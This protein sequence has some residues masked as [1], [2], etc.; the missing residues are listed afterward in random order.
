MTNFVHNILVLCRFYFMLSIILC[1]TSIIWLIWTCNNAF[2]PL[3]I[4]RPFSFNSKI[5]LWKQLNY[6][7]PFG[8]CVMF[9]KC[10]R[11]TSASRNNFILV[12]HYYYRYD[13][14]PYFLDLRNLPAKYINEQRV[15]YPTTSN[16]YTSLTFPP[17]SYSILFRRILLPK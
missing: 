1:V 2:S 6:I 16:P 14:F 11:T 7:K 5:L 13:S 4:D 12:I 15:L 3:I 17:T 9:T 8:E 10:V